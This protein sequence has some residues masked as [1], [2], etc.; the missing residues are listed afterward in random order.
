MSV[1]SAD[2]NRL[3]EFARNGQAA[4]VPVVDEH[5]RT[6]VL[7]RGV[8]S[9]SPDYGVWSGA[10]YALGAL[11][12]DMG[13]NE[14]FVGVVRDALLATDSQASLAG[15]RAAADTTIAARLGELG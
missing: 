13:M 12:F 7:S 1:S 8:V 10:G 15:L 3:D 9:N 6:S 5:D 14:Q 2:P 4:R 11:L